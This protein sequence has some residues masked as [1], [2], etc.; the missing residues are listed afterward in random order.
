MI[1][2]LRHTIPEVEQ[3]ICYGQ[4][5]LMVADGFYNDE[6]PKVIKTVEKLNVDAI[7]SSPLKRCKILAD[8]IS[9]VL[10]VE[11]VESD[12]FLMELNFGQWELWSWSQIFE[13]ER[14]KQI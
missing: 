2:F 3:G 1:Y 13:C 11:F 12:S 10:G 6:L 9:E 8:E 7:Y 14:G 4:S 5:D